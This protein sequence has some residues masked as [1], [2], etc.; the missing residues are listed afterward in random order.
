MAVAD[1]NARGGVRGQ[2]VRLL[3]GD[4]ACD[5]D[6]AVAVARKLVIDG[7]VFVVGHV[8]SHASIPASKVYEAA[9]I[10]MITPAST[11][12]KLT[13]EGGANI[14]RVC[15]RD[16]QQGLVAGNYLADEWGDKKIAILHDGS[17]YGMGLAD[18]TRKQLNKR[19]VVEAKYLD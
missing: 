2:Q 4:D 10:L 3:V 5:P 14:F 16:D 9:G 19:G 11:N 18:E 8:C 6:Q 17:T 15:G 13:D 7:A 1:L 12:P